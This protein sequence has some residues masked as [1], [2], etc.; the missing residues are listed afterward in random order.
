MVADSNG[1]F[2]SVSVVDGNS[3]FVVGSHYMS[4][5]VLHRRSAISKKTNFMREH[6]HVAKKSA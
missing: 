3:I 6:L 1:G 2:V 5:F 4:H